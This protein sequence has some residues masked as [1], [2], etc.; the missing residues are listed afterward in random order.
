MRC[1]E[2]IREV[3]SDTERPPFLSLSLSEGRYKSEITAHAETGKR[4]TM[5]KRPASRERGNA[6]GRDIISRERK[7]ARAGAFIGAT[8]PTDSP[9]WSVGEDNVALLLRPLNK[10]H[11]GVFL[12]VPH[13][14]AE[15]RP[16]TAWMGR[17]GA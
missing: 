14:L 7:K 11:A 13:G 5:V 15:Y 6:H 17:D 16:L 12:P 2:E 1:D 8:N 10:G 3:F 9:T 4:G